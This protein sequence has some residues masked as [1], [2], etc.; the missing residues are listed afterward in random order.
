MSEATVAGPASLKEFRFLGR[1]GLRVSPLSLGTMT[2]GTENGWGADEIEA[3]RIFDLYVDRGG[4]FI[5]TANVYTRGTSETM[6]GKFIADKRERVVVA[7]KYS[8]AT[9]PGNVNSG[10]NQRRNMVRAVEHSLKRLGTDYIDLYYL[11]AWEGNTPVE[12]VLRGFDDLVSSGKIVYVGLSDIPAWQVSRMQAIA[13]L[14]GWAP[15]VALQIEY[16]LVERTV[17]RDLM[18]MAR[19]MGIG[20][21]PWSPLAGG[22]LAGSY[23]RDDLSGTGSTAPGTRKASLLAGGKVTEAKLGIAEAVQSVANDLGRTPSQVALAWTLLDPAVTSTIMGARTSEQLEDNLGALGMVL[24]AGHRQLLD[25]VSRIP[26][27]FPHDFLG[28]EMLAK[29]LS[30]GETIIARR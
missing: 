28:S 23:T 4:N 25:D 12:E 13:E 17:E 5:D 30:A 20:V 7:T 1:S 16:S 29:A 10:G 24:D 22:L 27:G 14:R 21:I 11:H 19:E 26:K 8:G 2:F 15:V 18:P 6:L 9:E 3:R